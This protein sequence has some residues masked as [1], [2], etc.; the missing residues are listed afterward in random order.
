MCFGVSAPS[1]VANSAT[2]AGGLGLNVLFHSDG[3]QSYLHSQGVNLNLMSV[4]L[5]TPDPGL[6]WGG[7]VR[8]DGPARSAVNQP[9]HVSGGPSL[10]LSGFMIHTFGTLLAVSGAV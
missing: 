2:G 4:V 5:L 9:F 7:L 3:S 1:T 6:R 10:L 8:P